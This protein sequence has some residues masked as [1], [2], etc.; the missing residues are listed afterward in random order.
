MGGIAFVITVLLPAVREIKVSAERAVYF[1][2]VERQFGVQARV[3]T[4][5]A[6]LTGLYM[7][8]RLDLWDHFLSA[9]YWWMHAMV[10]LW[11]LFTF[12]LFVESL[13]S[14]IESLCDQLCPAAGG[15]ERLR[16]D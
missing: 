14:S 15:N 3:T 7:V 9:A 8:V 12:M 16:R 4:A 6:G 2:S 5:I 1:A 10:A 13:C 11:L